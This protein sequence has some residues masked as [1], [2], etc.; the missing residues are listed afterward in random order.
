M[1]LRPLLLNVPESLCLATLC[2]SSDVVICCRVL[3]FLSVGDMRFLIHFQPPIFVLKVAG[4][5]TGLR[6]VENSN[7]GGGEITMTW[8][9]GKSKRVTFN[10]S[11]S[12]DDTIGGADC[13]DSEGTE[14]RMGGI[15]RNAHG[16]EE[17]N[18][19]ER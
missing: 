5:L 15:C 14:E 2:S 4:D 19:G 9:S 1:R 6:T 7:Y 3:C 18:Q 8:W 17:R 12:A 10:A 13:M 11:S 16:L